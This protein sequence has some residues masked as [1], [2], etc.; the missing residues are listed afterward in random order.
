MYYICYILQILIVGIYYYA[1]KNL[2]KLT[3]IK[4]IS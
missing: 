2:R 3:F 1:C 4:K